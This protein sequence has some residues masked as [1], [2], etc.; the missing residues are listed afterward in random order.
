[1]VVGVDFDNTIV[2]YDDLFHAAAVDRGII[3]DGVPTSKESIRDHLR[4]RGQEE[5]WTELQ[6]YVYGVSVRHAPLFPGV[7]EFFARCRCGGVRVVIISHKTLVPFVG[8]PYD[9]HEAAEYA[10]RINGF[11]DPDRGGLRP[12]DVFFE[13]AKSSKLRRIAQTGC[14][15]FIDDLP[16]FLTEPGFPDEVDRVLF[17]PNRCHPSSPD[18]RLATSWTEIQHLLF[19]RA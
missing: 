12:D 13:L 10:L 7:A 9:L 14:T 3:P 4:A 16:E 11:Y 6:G 18:F 17:D 2:C 15:H 1:M 8:P 5:A 19:G